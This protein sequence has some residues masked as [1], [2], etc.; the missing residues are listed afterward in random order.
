MEMFMGLLCFCWLASTIG[1]G[2]KPEIQCANFVPE[3]TG[4]SCLCKK[5]SN[6]QKEVT[7][8]WDNHSDSELKLTNVQRKD[9]GTAYTCLM[10]IGEFLKTANYILRVAFGPSDDHLDVGPSRFDT[11]GSRTF[12]LTCQATEVYPPPEYRWSGITCENTNPQNVCVFTPNPARDHLRNVTCTSVASYKSQRP[13]RQAVKTIQLHVS[14]RPHMDC[15]DYVLEGEDAQCVCSAPK[16]VQQPSISWL[17]R[18]PSSSLPLINVGRKQDGTEYTCVVGGTGYNESAVYTLRVAL[19]P[20]MSFGN[21]IDMVDSGI[22]FTLEANPVPEMFRFIYLGSQLSS[23]PDKM[24]SEMFSSECT[25]S[26]EANFSATCSVKALDISQCLPGIYNVSV[27]N[28]FGSVDV[29]FFIYNK[30]QT[31]TTYVSTKVIA[32]A[33]VAVLLVVAVVVVTI[34]VVKKRACNNQC[35]KRMR[36]NRTNNGFDRVL[37]QATDPVPVDDPC[38]SP[39]SSVAET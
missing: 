31:E 17:G 11:N 32:G 4:V 23:A 28:Q 12:S 5:P 16:Y 33:F 13:P 29:T 2:A 27:S 3:N 25:Q 30:V 39:R 38:V 6:V 14:Q 1:Q 8:Y 22:S 20:R 26:S 35:S 36:Q 19:P 34:V 9:N 7:I 15:P 37:F 10:T 24:S 18:S 21:T